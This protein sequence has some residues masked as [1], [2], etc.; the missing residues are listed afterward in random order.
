MLLLKKNEH[1]ESVVKSFGL[2]N[3]NTLH[4]NLL[5]KYVDKNS[6]MKTTT[7]NSIVSVLR[8][9]NSNSGRRSVKEQ[10]NDIAKLADD[11]DYKMI[12]M[13]INCLNK[14]PGQERLEDDIRG[15]ELTGTFLDPVLNPI[16]HDPE[17]N[18][19]FRWLNTGVDDTQTL[20]PDGNIFEL[21]RTTKNK[22]FYWIC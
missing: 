16:F 13:L 22:V 19:L 9:L 21:C 10:I 6:V 15:A 7:F 3:L 5:Q 8:G 4:N 18:K 20:R 14:L 17:K 2:E 11:I 1:A 12:D